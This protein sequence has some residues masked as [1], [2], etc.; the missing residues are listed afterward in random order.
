VSPH[1][2]YACYPFFSANGA[3]P[4]QEQIPRL[5][6]LGHSFWLWS[7]IPRCRRRLKKN[8]TKFSM[9]GFP[10]IT[11]LCRFHTSALVKEVHRYGGVCFKGSLPHAKHVSVSSRWQPITPLGRPPFSY[12]K[13]NVLISSRRSAS[14][15]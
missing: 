7:A 8:S 5:Q 10:S 15:D 9:G 11:I 1:G 3:L 12:I 6:L 13:R 2:L 14:V 4:Q